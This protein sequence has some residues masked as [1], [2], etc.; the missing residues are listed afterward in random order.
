MTDTYI[1]RLRLFEPW[2]S[3][4]AAVPVAF[5]YL[6]AQQRNNRRLAI[7]IVVS[8]LFHAA[9]L[10]FIHAPV[11]N[12]SEP[13]SSGPQPLVVQL[14]PRIVAPSTTIS[15]PAERPE[16]KPAPPRPNRTILAVPKP[17]PKDP[18]AMVPPELLPPVVRQFD[19]PAPTDFS[20]M[21]EARRTQRRT[22]EAAL[23][24]ANAAARAGERTATP[25]EATNAAINRNL[26]TLGG[27]TGGTGG[28]FRILFMGHRTGQFAF[29]GWQPRISGGWR[30]VIEVDA[31]AGGDI[32][33]AM[34]RRMIEL[35]RKHYQGDFNW[36]S[37]RLGRVIVLSARKEDS[38][39]LEAF[40]KRE[41]F[42]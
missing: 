38:A 3:I 23:A 19:P 6:D 27:G 34:V 21:L 31:G 11:R 8:L 32:E 41:F 13:A 37:S 40:L 39:G 24:Q 26:Q 35:I 25:G 18:V 28:V 16:S 30:E 15:S 33:L 4:S 10:L 12:D 17:A 2:H 5:P 29:N 1:S 36:E 20:S 7:G 22:A 9:L 42:H 14:S